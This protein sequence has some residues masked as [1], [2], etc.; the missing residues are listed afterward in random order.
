M[1][2]A[3]CGHVNRNAL[4][5]QLHQAALATAFSGHGNRIQ[6]P[7]QP[8]L[9][10]MATVFSDHGNRI[11]RPWQPHLAAMAI[12]FD[13]HGKYIPRPRQP[14]SMA[15][16]TVFSGHG[17]QNF[18]RR[19]SGTRSSRLPCHATP[20]PWQHNF[21]G[22]IH[23]LHEKNPFYEE[24]WVSSLGERNWTQSL[25][26]FSFLVPH[27]DHFVIFFFYAFLSSFFDIW[28]FKNWE[29]FVEMLKKMRDSFE[30]SLNSWEGT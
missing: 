9:A 13:G 23:V 19:A 11:Q 29:T 1:A 10:A 28:S 5:L 14:H 30:E 16:A 18:P 21:H 7:W 22:K 17:N 3:F 20:F 12:A 26:H 8:H 4:L 6:R 15:I 2:I 25:P 27:K 24:K